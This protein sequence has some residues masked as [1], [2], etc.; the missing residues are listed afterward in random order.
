MKQVENSWGI[1][2][3]KGDRISC[4]VIPAN[5]PWYKKAILLFFR[6]G[7]CPICVTMSLIYGGKKLFKKTSK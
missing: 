5:L 4:P 3:F 1:K 2:E 7:L 6:F